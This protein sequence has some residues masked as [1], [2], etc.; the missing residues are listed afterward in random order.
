MVGMW[1]VWD[2][3]GYDNVYMGGEMSQGHS[4][5]PWSLWGPLGTELQSSAPTSPPPTLFS[6]PS[7][8]ITFSTGMED[9]NLDDGFKGKQAALCQRSFAIAFS[10]TYHSWSV[11]N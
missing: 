11:N 2:G 9:Y 3:T 1:P 5:L 10:M 6:M 4:S 7:G 8:L